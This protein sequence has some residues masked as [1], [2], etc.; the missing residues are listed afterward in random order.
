MKKKF[1]A[2]KLDYLANTYPPAKSKFPDGSDIEIFKFKSLQKISKLSKKKE[3]KEHVT[4]LFWK[5]PKKFKIKII[6]KK[7]NISN[8]KFS[9]DYKSDL[10]LVK[11]IS[12][13]IQVEKKHGTA[14]EIVSII[15]KD[16]LMKIISTRNQQRYLKNR[17]DLINQF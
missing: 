8:Y 3:D 14:E 9:I 16:R 2:K 5:N 13:K 12:K 7:K 15:E 4:H 1:F 17:K 6:N 11:K 10:T